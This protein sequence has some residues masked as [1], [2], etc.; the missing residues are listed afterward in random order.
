MTDF[1]GD[2]IES[3]CD[4]GQGCEVEGVAVALNHLRRHGGGF[5][6]EARAHFLFEFGCEVGEG[7][8]CSG[9]LTDT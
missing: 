5:Q 2:L 7:S 8:D 4:G 9:K 1:R 3:R 6:S